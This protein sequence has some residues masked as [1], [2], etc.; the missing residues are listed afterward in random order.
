MTLSLIRTSK[1][2]FF[3]E[4]LLMKRKPKTFLRLQTINKCVSE[5]VRNKKVRMKTVSS[6][7]KMLGL[8]MSSESLSKRRMTITG[9][10]KTRINSNNPSQRRTK[11]MTKYS[12]SERLRWTFSKCVADKFYVELTLKKQSRRLTKATHFPWMWFTLPLR[13]WLRDLLAP[14]TT[15]LP[16]SNPTIWR[17]LSLWVAVLYPTLKYC[18]LVLC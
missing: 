9:M 6:L 8:R 5:T 2:K 1:V 18:S 7:P 15:P 17:W 3:Q 13:T 16:R 4:N 12:I 10:K 14:T 11:V